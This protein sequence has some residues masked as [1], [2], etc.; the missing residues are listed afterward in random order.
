[1][2]RMVFV[3]SVLAVAAAYAGSAVQEDWSGIQGVLGPV[4]EWGA[5]FF[6]SSGIDPISSPGQL[7]MAGEPSKNVVTSTFEGAYSL[8]FCDFDGNGSVDV[9]G[10]AMSDASIRWWSNTDGSGT[11]WTQYQIA[12][13]PMVRRATCGDIDS[14]G[15]WDV[16]ACGNGGAVTWFENTD[17][18]GTDWTGNPVTSAG[19]DV[20]YLDCTDLDGDGRM[21]IVT[22]EYYANRIVWWRNADGTGG[23]WEE[24]PVDGGSNPYFVEAWDMDLDGDQDILG[25]LFGDMACYWWENLDGHGTSWSPHQIGGTLMDPRYLDPA[26][27][28]GDGDTDVLGTGYSNV[29]WWENKDG[30][31]T[32]W[33]T[34]IIDSTFLGAHDV[35]GSDLDCDGDQDV[36]TVSFNTEEILWW[37]NLD[38]A[39]NSW[40]EHMLD[41]FFEDG[42]AICVSDIDGNGTPDPLGAAYVDDEIA[43]WNLLEFSD[44]YLESSILDTQCQPDWDMLQVNA[45]VP[46]GTS[47]GCQL[48]CSEDYSQM[49][50]WSDTLEAPTSLAG[51][52]E[53]GCRYL[54]YRVILATQD[55]SISPV[56]DELT[57]TW[58]QL[59]MEESPDSGISLSVMPNPASGTAVLRITSPEQAEV[60]LRIFDL[61]GRMVRNIVNTLDPGSHLL[62][63]DDLLPGIYM[64]RMDMELGTLSV[65][66]VVLD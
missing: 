28:D 1:M 6:V 5:D 37:E 40:S 15:D 46:A 31:A 51:V 42:C 11:Q 19:A 52:L 32:A 18:S 53:D 20:Y 57:V 58:D 64:C 36:L 14:D 59:G 48:R 24:I 54:Q 16:A 25:S 35:E 12:S 60:S 9:L 26:D 44:G 55:P 50:G 38:G 39:G 66:L 62:S 49:G 34:H 30:T 23:S 7:T 41:P 8:D 21:D 33:E 47:L 22:A 13:M 10:G 3:L 61:S 17:G 45:V 4:I 29:L 27:V 63:T 65:R 43:W 56:L 2:R